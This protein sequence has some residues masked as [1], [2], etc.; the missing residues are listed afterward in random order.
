MATV[1]AVESSINKTI[2]SLVEKVKV[3]DVV[4]FRQKLFECL[5]NPELSLDW[6]NSQFKS[7]FDEIENLNS[8]RRLIDWRSGTV[9][10]SAARE[11][12]VSHQLHDRLTDELPR[13]QWSPLRRFNLDLQQLTYPKRSAAVV[14]SMRDDGVSIME[15]VAHHRAVGFQHV[16]IYT[17]DNIDGSDELLF[18]LSSQGFVT[19]IHNFTGGRVSPQRKAFAHS[20]EY[21]PELRDF[22]WVF[23]ADS[24]EFLVPSERFNFNILNVVKE[25]KSTYKQ[26][27]SP[28]AVCYHWKWFNS[29]YAIRRTQGFLLERYCYVGDCPRLIK[30]VVRLRD[31][32]SMHYLH[33]P[34]V[35]D[36]SFFVTPEIALIPESLPNNLKDIWEFANPHFSGGAINHYW[37]K[38]FEEFLIK[39]R[40]GDMLEATDQTN[41]YS[42]SLSQFFDWNGAD[43]NSNYDPPPPI[44]LDRVKNQVKIMS[45]IETISTAAKKL[46]DGFFD[47][48]NK[49]VGDRS[50]ETIY[51][52]AS[53]MSKIPAP[54]NWDDIDFDEAEYLDANPD[55][56][57]AVAS[58]VISS[59]AYHYERY[60]YLEGRYLRPGIRPRPRKTPFSNGVAPSRRDKLLANLDLERLQGVEVG[61]LAVPMVTKA[62][63]NIKYVDF[64]DTKTLRNL[65]KGNGDFDVN[66]IVEVDAVWGPASLSASLNDQRF[67]YVVASHVIEHVPDLIGWL[68]E[69]TSIL[70]EGGELRIVVPDPRY[71]Y[72]YLRNETK[73]YDVLEAYLMKRRVPSPRALIEYSTLIRVVDA[74]AA[75]RGELNAADLKP[76]SSAKEGIKLAT[77]SLE[78]GTYNDIHCWVFTP[79]S[80]AGLFLELAENGM[81]GFQVIKFFDTEDGGIE[82]VL[83]LG[84]TSDQEAVENSWRKLQQTLQLP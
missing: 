1:S 24:D 5:L 81:N 70:N 56:A 8:I 2:S 15:W 44:L 20:L 19:L 26:G 71:T 35:Q 48:I 49:I 83:H 53:A 52:E 36:G 62:E 42:R 21:L 51:A 68:N 74:G 79:E 18:N 10:S 32:L 55:V 54:M 50:I 59:G 23:Y 14:V 47:M 82:F 73:F 13:D 27:K 63:G 16:F 76:M 25:I 31:V 69:V 43:T 3:K 67:D 60:G 17:N 80:F 77:E 45:E 11:Y 66:K 58:K 40:R 39:K 30:S 78:K 7:E 61:A 64:A 65:Y 84:R 12:L 75:W 37:C 38:S 29:N 41:I 22:E 4:K 34:E 72:D 46:D 28:S 33:F 57:A 9:I 6:I